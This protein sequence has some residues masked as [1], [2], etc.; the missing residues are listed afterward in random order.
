MR[1]ST[2]YVMC[3][4]AGIA[5]SIWGRDIYEKV[6]G[7]FIQPEVKIEYRSKEGIE[8][9]TRMELY[10]KDGSKYTLPLG[11]LADLIKDSGLEQRTNPRD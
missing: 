4:I 8:D 3:T 1:N 2:V 9:I 11:R 10:T 7:K 5:G 6:R